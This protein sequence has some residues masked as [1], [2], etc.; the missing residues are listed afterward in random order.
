MKI[1]IGDN[2]PSNFIDRWPGEFEVFSHY[3]MALGI[4][5]S[6]FLLPQ[7]KRMASRMLVFSHGVH[8]VETVAAILHLR[9]FSRK[10]ILITTYYGQKNF[11]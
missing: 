8:S 7:S 5:H 4:P 2:R 9:R 10:R 6:L 11:V 3:E 1:E